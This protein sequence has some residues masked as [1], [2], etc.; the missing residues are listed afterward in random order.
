MC[1][2]VCKIQ[3][4]TWA[5]VGENPSRSEINYMDMIIIVWVEDEVVKPD[6]LVGKLKELGKLG[7][8]NED[9]R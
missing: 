5:V 6:I 1:S 9:S 4:I 2:H 3:D 7:A 8:C